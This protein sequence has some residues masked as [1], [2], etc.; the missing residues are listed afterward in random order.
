MDEDLKRGVV[1][2]M[3]S[4][5]QAIKDLIQV[6]KTVTHLFRSKIIT[7]QIFLLLAF[8]DEIHV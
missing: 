8:K 7:Q 6:L 4:R 5:L 3:G 2:F 1:M